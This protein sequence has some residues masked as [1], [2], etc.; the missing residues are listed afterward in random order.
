M[1]DNLTVDY[2]DNIIISKKS[3][4]YY[5]INFTELSIIVYICSKKSKNA[6]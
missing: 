4:N 5:L 6:L 2:E 3:K 1:E